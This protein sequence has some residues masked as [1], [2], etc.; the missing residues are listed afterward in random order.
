METRSP[1]ARTFAFLDNVLVGT[2]LLLVLQALIPAGSETQTSTAY[3][4]GDVEVARHGVLVEWL[5]RVRPQST[6]MAHPPLFFVALNDGTDTG[7]SVGQDG[8]LFAAPL[9]PDGYDLAPVWLL[10]PRAL[11]LNAAGCFVFA[12]ILAVASAHFVGRDPAD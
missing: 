7:F 4:I 11:A 6:G 2:A 10:R 5:R 1:L 3:G 8:V 12:A 9:T